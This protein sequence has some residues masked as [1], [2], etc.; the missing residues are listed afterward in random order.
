MRKSLNARTIFYF[1]WK[2][3]NL[4]KV[5]TIT[6]KLKRSIK[7][8]EKRQ[9]FG[10]NNTEGFC[11]H[12]EF[13]DLDQSGDGRNGKIGIQ[14]TLSICRVCVCKFTHSLK[15]TRSPSNEYCL[16]LHSHS[17]T[18]A[19]PSGEKFK[20]PMAVPALIRGSSW[21]CKGPFCSLL[22]ATSSTCL[23]F[24][25]VNLSGLLM[26]SWSAIWFL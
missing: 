26:Y 15:Y 14:W 7:K 5:L 17:Q 12:P 18:C 19:V 13:T 16:C 4:R 8:E 21:C 22:S 11:S 3:K 1:I 6:K 25:L 9:G 24:L 2:V 20:S 23:C 10:K